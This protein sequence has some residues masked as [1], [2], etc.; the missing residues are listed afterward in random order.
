MSS[1]WMMPSS[2]CAR[3]VPRTPCTDP[4]TP[5]DTFPANILT[6]RVGAVQGRPVGEGVA[7]GGGPSQVPD[8]Q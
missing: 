6:A 3:R 5:P 4:P 8:P 1:R 7:E 2:P